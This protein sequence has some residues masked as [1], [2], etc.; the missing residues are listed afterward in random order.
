MLDVL[1]KLQL[2]LEKINNESQ[3]NALSELQIN[4]LKMAI[5]RL[6]ELGAMIEPNLD[7]IRKLPP[8]DINNYDLTKLHAGL[9]NADNVIV[10]LM[11]IYMTLARSVENVYKL[12]DIVI[13]FLS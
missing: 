12:D 5:N 9:D 6:E 4:E 2:S 13:F 10:P 7:N 1:K 11:E 3:Y 8:M